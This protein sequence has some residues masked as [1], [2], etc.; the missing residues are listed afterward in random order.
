MEKIFIQKVKSFFRKWMSAKIIPY[1][2][3]N[4]WRIF[5]CHGKNQLHTPVTIKEGAYVGMRATILSRKNRCNN[6]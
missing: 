6:W 1:M 2:V 4:G 3:L 5:A